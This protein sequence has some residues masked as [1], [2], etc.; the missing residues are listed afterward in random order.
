MTHITVSIGASRNSTRWNNTDF[1]WPEFVAE[2]RRRAASMR[3]TREQ[4]Q[5]LT[6]A[7]RGEI[8]DVGGYVTGALKEGTTRR[9]AD[10]I[11]SR[12]LIALDADHGDDEMTSVDL[13]LALPGVAAALHPSA[14]N[15]PGSPRQRLLIPLSRPITDPLEFEAVSRIVA[16][17]LGAD[18]FDA[19]SYDWNRLMYWPACCSDE[20]LDVVEVAGDPLDPDALLAEWGDWS[21]LSKLPGERPA[22]RETTGDSIKMY[23]A[24]L[25]GLRGAFHDV[26]GSIE[27]I[28]DEHLADVYRDD[29]VLGRRTLVGGDSANG[30]VLYAHPSDPH[31]YQFATSHHTGHDPASELASANG[32]ELVK[33]HLFGNGPGS[34]RKMI[35]WVRALPDMADSVRE[36][37]DRRSAQAAFGE[38]EDEPEDK[39]AQAEDR[40]QVVQRAVASIDAAANATELEQVVAPRIAS[41]EW[42]AAERERL[43]KAM[44]RR[45]TQVVGTTLPIATARAWVNPPSQNAAASGG[46]PDW[47]SRWV[48]VKAE[49]V[50]FSLDRKAAI[51]ARAF[52]A[53]HTDRMPLRNGSTTLRERASEFAV[54]AWAIRTV[55]RTLYAPPEQ[56]VFEQDKVTYA[57]LYDPD[58]APACEPGGEA[59]IKMVLSHLERMFPDKREREIM[60]SWLAHVVR[61]PGRKVRWAPYIFGVEGAGKSFLVDLLEWTMGAPNVRRVS[62]RDLLSDFTGWAAGRS[63][64]AVEEAHQ[65]GHRYEAAEVLKAPVTNDRISVH[66]KGRDAYEIINYVC[67]IILSNHADGI[68]ITEH[69]RRYFF[70]QS[71]VSVEEATALSNEGFFQNLFA[72]CRQSRGQLRRWLMQEVQMHPE[73]DPDGRAPITATRGRVIELTKSDA[74][75]VVEELLAGRQAVTSPH[76]HSRLEALGVGAKT[77]RLGHL[78]GA[79]GFVFYKKM[80]FGK[81]TVRVWVRPG[82]VADG[83]DLAVRNALSWCLADEFDDYTE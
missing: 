75:S 37:D 42:S 14:S 83:D 12:S 9:K 38:F 76:V 49:G 60:L 82:T 78:I 77:S 27:S 18:R 23:P 22:K 43:A 66:M 19:A 7:Q 45:F 46:A 29:G 2:L 41:C 47:L 62:G 8:K 15:A 56:E 44:Q 63:V 3:A 20:Q 64:T 21:D 55:D 28:I 71:A 65:A 74:Q 33:V 48:Y 51:D 5:A 80:R 54:H 67:Y 26:Y 32:W 59:A 30:L 4:F 31:S 35:D 39:A 10:S 17:R 50:F 36:E 68:P 81:T 53:E 16:G 40:E 58:S 25:N 69:D 13:D 72:T 73:F 79:A 1:T 61:H 24:H 70:L 6:K 52:D 34:E 11:E 57:N